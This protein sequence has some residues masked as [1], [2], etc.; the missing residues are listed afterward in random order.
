MSTHDTVQEVSGVR[1]LVCAE[2]GAPLAGAADANDFISAAWAGEAAM[3]AIPV[4]RLGP[5]FL[6]LSSRVAGEV[7][8]KFVN[9]RMRVVIVGDIGAWTKRS[10]PLRDFV[11]ESNR[12]QAV[13]FVADLAA[14]AARTSDR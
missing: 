8:Q 14:L 9:Y 5:D 1:V 2:A 4:A 11:A 7:I 12:G 13:W 3:V 6:H 10:G